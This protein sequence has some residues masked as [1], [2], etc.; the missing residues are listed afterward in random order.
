M[1]KEKQQISKESLKQNFNS[2]EK[3]NV[4]KSMTRICLK[5]Q[6]FQNANDVIDQCHD[7]GIGFFF[8]L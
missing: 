4:T 1:S 6:R 7:Y 8:G 2:S 3:L 5:R